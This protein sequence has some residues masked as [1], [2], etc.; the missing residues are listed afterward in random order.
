MFS[1]KSNLF[2]SMLVEAKD[3]ARKINLRRSHP[4][5][6]EMNP[7]ELSRMLSELRLAREHAQL[8]NVMHRNRIL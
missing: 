3:Y 4:P 2:V 8:M 5:N 6:S 1:L 7:R